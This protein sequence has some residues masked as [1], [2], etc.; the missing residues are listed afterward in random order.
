MKLVLDFVPNHLGMDHPWLTAKSDLFVQSPTRVEGTFEQRTS[1]GVRWIANG[2]D[3]YFPPWSDVAQLDYRRT[4]TRAA[5]KELLMS[6]ATRCDG[7]RCDMAMLLLNEV[8][9]RTWQ[10]FPSN[11]ELP[12]TEFWAEVIP[13][14]KRAHPGFLFLAEVYWGL[15]AG[16]QSLGFDYTYDKQLYDDLYWKNTI[17]V[18]KRLLELYPGFVAASAHFLEN[19]D[20]PR[21]AAQLSVA[22]QRASALVLLGLPGMRFLHEGQL[23]GA[24]VKI[25]VQLGR[26]KP[27]P[28]QREVQQMY[29]SILLILQKSAVG[30][31]E[32][33][34]LRPR[35]A[36]PGNPTGQNFVIV[37]WQTKPPEFDLVVVNL[38][39][40]RSQCYARLTAPGLAE[41][42]WVMENL[43]GSER[44]ERFGADLASQG[45]YLDLPE[46]AA[47]LFRFRPGR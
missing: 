1:A 18:Q 27:E 22:E 38:A 30:K 46:H 29:E 40:H 47:Q 37:Q 19:H 41:R 5:M 17:G 24:K 34:L 16:L 10:H 6:V 44:Y 23:V 32:G 25:P 42:N 14:V 2:K 12:L 9:P 35:V 21:I 43:L 20:E 36:W 39:G 11:G 28:L 4:D 13:S 3:P 15:E 7:L 31:G 8:F 33:T 45:V 26:R